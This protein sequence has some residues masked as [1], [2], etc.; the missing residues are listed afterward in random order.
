VML[1]SRYTVNASSMGYSIVLCTLISVLCY[2]LLL[3]TGYQEMHKVQLESRA[4]LA[5]TLTQ[6]EAYYLNNLDNGDSAIRANDI[7]DNG[8][9]SKAR[10]LQW[11]GY[12]VLTTSAWF[13]E[14]TLSRSILI[15]KQQK[16]PVALYLTDRGRPLQLSGKAQIKGTKYVPNGYLKP[17]YLTGNSQ[18]DLKKSTGAIKKS[19]LLLPKATITKNDY[20]GDKIS[21][22]AIYDEQEEVYHSFS[23]DYPL[24]ITAASNI[25]NVSISGFVMIS[26]KDSLYIDKSA[27]LTNVLIEA[28]VVTIGKGF[29]G[30]LQIYATEA[31]YIEEKASLQYPSSIYL[32][33]TIEAP[34]VVVAK[35]AKVIG[36]IAL[37]S[38]NNKFAP[39]GI[40]DIT[41]SSLV[42]GGVYCKARLSIEGKIIG[43]VYTEQFYLKTTSGLYDNYIHDGVIDG[44]SLPEGF[45][46]PAMLPSLDKNITWNVIKGL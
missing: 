5:H 21:I 26:S 12:K 44:R 13:K 37:T 6:A 46:V 40:L 38:A 25:K 9:L 4:T 20:N 28:P 17:A 39:K 14:D 15:G 23:S 35:D 32:N 36:G 34:K 31:V 19:K 16:L 42:V 3:V 10:H 45:V 24:E 11:G 27:N 2:S 30:N 41:S 18:P 1:P 33:A 22:E 43:A 29:E 8:M 7:L